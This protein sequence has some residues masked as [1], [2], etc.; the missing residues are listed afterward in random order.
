MKQP[1]RLKHTG[2]AEARKLLASLDED[3]PPDPVGGP[4]RILR[5]LDVAPS[6][7]SSIPVARPSASHRWGPVASICGLVIACV[8]LFAMSQRDSSSVSIAAGALE[9]A[10]AP[11]L[12]VTAVAPTAEAPASAPVDEAPRPIDVHALASAPV[13]PSGPRAPSRLAGTRREHPSAANPALEG[14]QARGSELTDELQL[15]ER[16]QSAAARGQGAEALALVER[17]RREFPGGRFAVEMSVVEIE[18]LARAGRLD[19]AAA[20]GERFLQ[21]HPGSPYTRR[22]EAVVRQRGQKEQPR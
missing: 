17:H 11:T 14:T 10:P 20:R 12:V 16:A 13:E 3:V 22:V 19:E 9:P 18:S 1:Q 8:G 15:L 4:D 7:S 2:S 6:S 21:N 5:A